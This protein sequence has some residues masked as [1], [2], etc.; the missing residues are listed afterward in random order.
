MPN[1]CAFFIGIRTNLPMQLLAKRY[2]YPKILSFPYI[3]GTFQ[4]EKFLKHM[5]F[6]P[7]YLINTDETHYY[8]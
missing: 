7:F 6:L 4:I 8:W 1:R 5:I 2:I 3:S